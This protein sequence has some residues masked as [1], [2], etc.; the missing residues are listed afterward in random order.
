MLY[1]AKNN[2]EEASSRHEG[3][4][5]LLDSSDSTDNKDKDYKRNGAKY[6]NCDG[7]IAGNIGG[8][9]NTGTRGEY[10]EMIRFLSPSARTEA[11]GAM[12]KAKA[13]SST[14]LEGKKKLGKN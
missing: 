10:S 8:D 3:E 4:L 1:D 13:S 14:A 5:P 12:A 2:K 9:S 11:L 7:A 6:N